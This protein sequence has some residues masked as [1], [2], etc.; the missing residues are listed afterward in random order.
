MIW[1]PDTSSGTYLFINV[2][3]VDIVLSTVYFYYYILPY[4]QTKGKC[5]KTD[6]HRKGSLYRH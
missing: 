1:A 3:Y 4:D 6:Y 5:E 2:G